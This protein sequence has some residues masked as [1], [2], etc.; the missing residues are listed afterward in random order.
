MIADLAANRFKEMTK[1][2]DQ[3][4]IN[5][6]ARGIDRCRPVEAIALL[7][8]F[9]LVAGD[10]SLA[11]IMDIIDMCADYDEIAYDLF[12][13]SFADTDIMD[14]NLVDSWLEDECGDEW[15]PIKFPE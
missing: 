12:F 2:L 15:D 8:M 9:F 13:D 7:K 6:L 10:K 11:D 14:W 5:V 3:K 4:K 1:E